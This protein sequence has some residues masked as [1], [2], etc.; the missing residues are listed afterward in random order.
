LDTGCAKKQ[1]PLFV[2]QS[3]FA[4][5]ADEPRSVQVL[6]LD[7]DGLLDVVIGALGE[8]QVDLVPNLGAGRL[9]LGT[10][11]KLV[12][13]DQVVEVS[14]LQ[15]AARGPTIAVLFESGVALINDNGQGYQVAADGRVATCPLC[16]GF[17]PGDFD[18]DGEQDLFVIGRA[19]TDLYV[20]P[21]LSVAQLPRPPTLLVPPRPK[22]IDINLD[23]V[24]DLLGLRQLNG[25]TE[26][27]VLFGS[28]SGAFLDA[29]LPGGLPLPLAMAAADINGDSKA[30]IL[31]ASAGALDVA[32]NEGGHFVTSLHAE[33]PGL[34]PIGM[35]VLDANGD[36]LEDLVISDR[37]Q[38]GLRVLLGAQELGFLVAPT[39]P[40]QEVATGLHH[41]D[42]DQDGYDELLVLTPK[43]KD[44]AA[45]G[46]YRGGPQNDAL[47]LLQLR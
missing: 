35:E 27:V 34:D 36:G 7:G 28:R 33:L 40:L 8:L 22:A 6:D 2:D 15:R 44:P 39:L 5:R 43:G 37:G 47:E 9:G 12:A 31:L 42:L 24:D 19:G 14:A 16:R 18:G 30:D 38:P 29:P 1:A 41:G 13:N 11:L 10:W 3:H 45:L 25:V 46:V 20:G 32:I 23:G 17:A 4:L 26:P 21:S